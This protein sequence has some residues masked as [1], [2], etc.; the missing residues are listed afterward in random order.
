MNADKHSSKYL[1]VKGREEILINPCKED[2]ISD[3]DEQFYKNIIEGDSVNNEF[4]FILD[5]IVSS[6]QM[7]NLNIY[8]C[9]TVV[10]RKGSPHYFI[11]N[12]D[13]KVEIYFQ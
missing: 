13:K 12:D 5:R 7:V 10:F 2:F 6:K 11:F 9:D 8:L 3:Y 4:S 1:H